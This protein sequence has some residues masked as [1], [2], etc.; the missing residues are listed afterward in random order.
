MHI[1]DLLKTYLD[2]IFYDSNIVK[3]DDIPPCR[4][5][6]IPFSARLDTN[7]L[8]DLQAQGQ[9]ILVITDNK[10]D[11]RFVD[12]I[13]EDAADHFIGCIFE[14]KAYDERLLQELTE[15][16]AVNTV[17]EDA[18]GKSYTVRTWERLPGVAMTAGGSL[19][20]MA[21]RPA[22]GSWSRCGVKVRSDID[23][24]Q[25]GILLTSE[26]YA[27][28]RMLK[29]QTVDDLSFREKLLLIRFV[30]QEIA[31][32]GAMR[33]P[34]LKRRMIFFQNGAYIAEAVCAAPRYADAESFLYEILIGEP[35]QD[36]ARSAVRL[37]DL[38]NPEYI[39]LNLVSDLEAAFIYR[40]HQSAAFW[41]AVM[42]RELNYQDVTG[43][44][45][46]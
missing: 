44:K 7:L 4:A 21:F 6:K 15:K 13:N 23:K 24:D 38:I 22:D 35:M 12:V 1:D 27:E 40:T 10:R 41:A 2:K 20:L 45:Q 46:N 39:T 36:A 17:T 30:M 29:A 42:D 26:R 32:S 25:T 19:V 9:Y 18:S 28:D 31:E 16:E 34:D 11:K 14:G 37:L 5:E 43:Q 3:A 33:F 8:G